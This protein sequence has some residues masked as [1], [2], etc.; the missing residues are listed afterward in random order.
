MDFDRSR[1]GIRGSIERNTQMKILG[2]SMGT[3]LLV[4]IALVVGK[5]FGSVIP[6]LKSVT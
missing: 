3:I 4:L 1:D 2:I 5:K 6:L